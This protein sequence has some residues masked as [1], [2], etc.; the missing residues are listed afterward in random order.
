MTLFTLRYLS[1]RMKTQAMRLG[2][3]IP[4]DEWI[5]PDEFDGRDKSAAFR[6]MA[7]VDSVRQINALKDVLD[8]KRLPS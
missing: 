2:R 4:Y 7:Y 5:D 3:Y 1:D 8:E 6:C